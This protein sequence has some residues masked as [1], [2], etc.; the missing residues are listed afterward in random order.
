[1]K[2]TGRFFSKIHMAMLSLFRRQSETTQL[3]EEIQFHLDQQMKE[4]MTAGATPEE[5]RKAALRAFGN[6]TLLRE[7]A[8]ATWSW[9]WL[10]V[11]ARDLRYGARRLVRSPGFACIA[12][13]V[14]ALGIGAA[15]SLFTMVR[16]VLLKPLPFRD[17]D[18]LVNVYEHFRENTNASGF[19]VVSPADFRDWRAQTHGFEDMG[20][21]RPTDFNLSG[22]HS[23][24][25]E[26]VEGA[27]FSSSLLPVLGVQPVLGR[28]FTA[29]EDE[30]DA[31]HVVIL[32]WSLF[33]RRFGG[34]PSILGTQIH[35]N[36]EPWTIIGVLPGWF[37]YPDAR[38]Q[39]IVPWGQTYTPEQFSHHDMHQSYVVARLRP[40]VSAAAAANEIG[41]LQYRLH[42][43][44]AS[45][46]VAE[47]IRWR[48][49]IDD[50]VQEVRKPLLVL[51]SAVGCMLLIACLNVSNLLVARSAA[52]RKEVAVRGALGGSRLALI[53]EQMTES[54]LICIAGGTLGLLLSI[55]VTRW[56]ATHWSDLP[57]AET[58][59]IDGTVF[60]FSAGIIV[61]CAL[62]AGLLPAISST[63]TGVLAA[64]Q[65]SS[66]SIGGSVARATLRKTL[67]VAEIALTVILL[68]SAGLLFK[69]FLHL[70]TT[71]LGCATDHALTMKYTLPRKQYDT[72]A[73]ILAFHENLLERVRRVPGVRAAAL[74]ST[75]PGGGRENDAIFTIPG[76]PA[77]AG[78]LL[79]NDAMYY[80]I[81]P[82]YFSTMQIPLIRGRFFTEQ[83]RLDRYHYIVVSKKFADQYFP[84]D[85]AIGRH[86]SMIWA[87]PLPES[88]EIIGVVGNTLFDV[89][90]PVMATVYFPIFAG[91]PI[92]TDDAALVVRTSTD[93]LN[94]AVPV[95]QQFAAIDPSLPVS[96]VLTMQQILGKS[97]ASENL[98]A[99]LL[100]S[101][102]TLSLLLAAIGLYGVLSYLVTQRITEIG[103]RIALGAQRRQ[104]LQL[105]LFDGLKP[106][107]IGLL[108][109]ISG[110]I[111]AGALIR[112]QLYGTSPYDPLVF[113]SMVCSLLM[114]AVIACAVPAIRASRIEPMQALR[115]E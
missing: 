83:E 87:N 97:T 65:E 43:Q 20:A 57:R 105:V 53:R 8:R 82:S 113:V 75:P 6:P 30:P 111:A 11:G 59:H 81:D 48:P 54:L 47:E 24:L 68:V 72:P 101:F 73:K 108:L 63:G 115:T 71:D 49:M 106:V 78:N 17:P 61:F 22:E 33:Q 14:M 92:A 36:S 4:N 62:F 110:G 32:T 96:D 107:F 94:F 29:Q 55:V 9:Q 93:P 44:H 69:S 104:V 99:T 79:Q 27:G 25:P 85:S 37:V 35:V 103:I 112:S 98:S 95:Q 89:T 31:S 52:R 88:F 39:L 76:H 60:L 13:L 23:E 10:E 77:A 3:N 40:G 18:K 84:G 50:V 90:R 102:A 12:I 51:L 86:I 67:L 56:F 58:V 45:E 26:A 114:T 74:V 2:Y 28:N 91:L 16:S 21:W 46:P 1:M 80:S 70:R 5:A 7:Q 66:R 34:N 42:L 15:T 109:G 64:L 41:A 100:L 38:S 19:N